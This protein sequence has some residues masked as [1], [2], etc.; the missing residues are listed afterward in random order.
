M[1]NCGFKLKCQTQLQLTPNSRRD[2]ATLKEGAICAAALA[3]Q[4]H[5][6]SFDNPQVTQM[7][8]R[9][10]GSV[11]PSG[12]VITRVSQHQLALGLTVK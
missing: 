4:H 7:R 9:K 2:Y 8:G 11:P 6:I 10:G 12:M 3:E 1:S 5:V